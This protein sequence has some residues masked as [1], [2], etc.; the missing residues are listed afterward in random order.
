MSQQQNRVADIWI[1]GDSA[2][3]FDGDFSKLLGGFLAPYVYTEDIPEFLKQ[4]A[5]YNAKVETGEIAAR[6]GFKPY[7]KLDYIEI[8]ACCCCLGAGCCECYD[9]GWRAKP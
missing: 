1:T 8:E 7:F 3:V 6:Y 9:R 4:K 2:K 5:E